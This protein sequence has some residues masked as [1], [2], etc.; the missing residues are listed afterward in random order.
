MSRLGTRRSCFWDPDRSVEEDAPRP[1]PPAEGD[2][3]GSGRPPD[4]LRA[5]QRPGDP[6]PGPGAQARRGL[7]LLH[8][9]RHH[10]ALLE[11]AP[12]I[13]PE[14]FAGSPI[15]AAYLARRRA[16]ATSPASL[17]S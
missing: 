4:R 10:A 2:E 11:T 12:T 1:A 17:S 13:T 7:G 8:Q 5:G 14:L 16:R 15:E 6:P 9:R 3:D